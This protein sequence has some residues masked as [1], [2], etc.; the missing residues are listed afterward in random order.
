MRSTGRGGFV[1]RLRQ[2]VP[3]ELSFL[4]R[5]EVQDGCERETATM[6][7]VGSK[8]PAD[9]YG[10]LRNGVSSLGCN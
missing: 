8:R 9:G 6:L 3:Q 2:S 5:E 1:I 7:A 4:A 10:H